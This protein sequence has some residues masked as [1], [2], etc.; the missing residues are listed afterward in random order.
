MRAPEPPTVRAPVMLHQWRRL[1][2]LH[3]RYPA[4]V[5]QDLLPEG[6]R[7]QTFDGDAWV[8]LVPFLMRG[9]RAPGTPPAPWLSAFPETN[10]RTY[11][12]ARD[13]GAGI[14]FL[15]LDAARLPAVL[16]A[17]ATYGLPYYWSS[18]RVD[19][20]GRYL[21]Y[22]SRRRWP[23]PAGARADADIAAGPPIPERELGPLDHFLTARYRLYSVVAGRLVAADAE[24]PP[25]PL[26]R[27]RVV[28]LAQDVVR[29]QGLPDPGGEPL[30][31]ASPGV[32]VRIGM[33]RS[34]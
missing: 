32:R 25:W 10:V 6:L 8:G 33:W 11:V 16:A 17:R 28:Y 2:F 26:H 7:V 5:V 21:T 29:A 20:G 9:V 30:V 19:L 27:G 13:G 24:H 14:W 1:T 4:D 31:H 18:M 15:S 23:A 12:E 3:W 34:V 22:R